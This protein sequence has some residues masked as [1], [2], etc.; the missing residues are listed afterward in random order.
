[1]QMYEDIIFEC[2]QPSEWVENGE[3]MSG[4]LKCLLFFDMI[5]YVL[6]QIFKRSVWNFSLDFHSFAIYTC[7]LDFEA[8]NFVYFFPIIPIM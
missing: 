5:G 7:W 3:Y 8:T 4:Q 1:M 6:L 2:G